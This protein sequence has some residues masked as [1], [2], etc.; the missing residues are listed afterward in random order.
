MT[1]HDLEYEYNPRVSTPDVE[2]YIEQA[3]L[4]SARVRPELEGHYDVR[5][6]PQS[7]MTC[8]IFP[9]GPDAPIHVFFHGGYWRGRDKS[10]Y[11]FMVPAF[12]EA[13]VTLVL[14]NY[15]LCPVVDLKTIVRQTADCLNWVKA[16]GHQWGCDTNRISASGHSAGAHLLAMALCP[17]FEHAIAPDVVRNVVLISGLFELAPVASISVNED[18]RLT[19]SLIE[20]LS[21][22]RHPP[23]PDLN[24]DILVGGNE[25][26][27]WIGQSE[28]YHD[29]VK[30][31]VSN[32]SFELLTGH[33]HFSIVADFSDPRSPVTKA[34]IDAAL[35]A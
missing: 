27:S 5:Y 14:P 7:L 10:D 12:L 35:D 30:D 32:A 34:C 6:G 24:L 28:D 29:Y 17:D 1:T 33:D 20:E 23:Y 2:H 11:S 13:G 4:E 9:A 8:D 16:H 3:A 25:T 15:D 19:P 26:D 18:I 21:P 22:M 31:K